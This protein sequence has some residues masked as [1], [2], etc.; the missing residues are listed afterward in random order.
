MM[1]KLGQF[2]HINN[3][4]KVVRLEQRVIFAELVFLHKLFDF[5]IRSPIREND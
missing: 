5:R 4:F 2:E 1:H 3:L